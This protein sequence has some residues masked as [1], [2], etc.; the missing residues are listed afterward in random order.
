VSAPVSVIIPSYQSEAT[1]RA[2]LASV[3]NQDYP[4]F[5]EVIVV[6]SCPGKTREIIRAEFPAVKLIQ[7]SQRTDPAAA[8][9]IGVQASSGEFLAFIDSDCSADP[10][11]LRRLL[12]PLH[13]NFHASGGAVANANGDNLVSW[14][15]YF[16]EFR[17]FLPESRPGPVENLTLGNAAY[18]RE[19]FC[20]AGGFPEG[21]FPQEDQVFHHTFTEMGNRI[22]F[23][24]SVVVYHH[25]RG[26]LAD[27]LSH[28]REIG[29]ANARVVAQLDLPGVALARRPSLARLALPALVG[30]R[31]LRTMWVCR[32]SASGMIWRQP[33]LAALVASGIVAWGRGFLEG[34]QQLKLKEYGCGSVR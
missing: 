21:C 24:P 14:A 10:S 27:F 34:A 12:E 6:D 2:C 28:Q 5:Y 30:F 22:Y 20:Q 17:E 1:I 13:S 29:R 25:H 31:W 9:N 19:A 7:L 32:S 11:W 16:C 33:R 23:D 15:G 18:R 4:G 26:K 8:R 3:L